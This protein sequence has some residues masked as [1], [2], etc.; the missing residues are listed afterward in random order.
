M[1]KGIIYNKI[2]LV[3]YMKKLNND[4]WG[5]GS[6]ILILLLLF[7]AILLVASMVN[8]YDNRLPSSSRNRDIT[9]DNK[10]SS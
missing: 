5:M 1:I 8:E 9:Y 2:I 10:Y 3:I 6:F 4:G 7:C